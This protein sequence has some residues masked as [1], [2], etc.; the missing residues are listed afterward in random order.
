MAVITG[1][2]G[3]AVVTGAFSAIIINVYEWSLSIPNDMFEAGIFGAVTNTIPMYRGLYQV[4]GTI[5][6]HCPLDVGV[7]VANFAVGTAASTLTLTASTGRTYSGPAHLNFA[8]TVER[9]GGLVDY[10]GTFVS[11]GDW[12]FA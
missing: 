2:T 4:T 1:V 8:Q 12:A 10:D 7:T 11:D 9:V 5:K 6:G 3:N